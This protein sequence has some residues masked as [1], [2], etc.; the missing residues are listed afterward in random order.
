MPP[1]PSGAP[2]RSRR[3][4]PARCAALV[5]QVLALRREALAGLAREAALAE[6]VHAADRVAQERGGAAGGIAVV[7]RA[8]RLLERRFEA[9]EELVHPRLQA[10]MLADQR[11]AGHHANHAGVLLGEG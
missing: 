8:Q 5:E 9:V 1:P 11:I 10:L 6:L 2:S 3:T 7:G 4:P